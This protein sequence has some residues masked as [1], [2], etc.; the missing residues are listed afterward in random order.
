MQWTCLLKTLQHAIALYVFAAHEKANK[1]FLVKELP[2]KRESAE[3]FVRS[4]AA[5]GPWAG[6]ITLQI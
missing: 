6:P 1:Q 3:I 5:L 4:W 2:L